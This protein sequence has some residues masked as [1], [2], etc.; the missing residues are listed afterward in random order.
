MR[1]RRRPAKTLRSAG[2]NP[3]SRVNPKRAWGTVNVLAI[4]MMLGIAVLLFGPYFGPGVV[5]IDL[6]AAVPGAPAASPSGDEAAPAPAPDAPEAP[7]KSGKRHKASKTAAADDD[8]PAKAKEAKE[9]KE[10]KESK[11]A[12]KADR[13]AEDQ[14]FDAQG[15][16]P[17]FK[18][19]FPPEWEYMGKD[20][21]RYAEAT[22][23][24]DDYRASGKESR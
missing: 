7:E 6:E 2:P 24:E 18:V 5:H 23:M 9:G 12:I 4:I 3:A 11:A 16:V 17:Y 15:V 10:G 13:L 8:T 1:R 14:F 19:E 22:M 20:P 21:R